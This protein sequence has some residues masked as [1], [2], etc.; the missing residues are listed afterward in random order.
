VP[1]E[2]IGANLA[3]V[4]RILY[5]VVPYLAFSMIAGFI[6]SKLH[7]ISINI[8]RNEESSLYGDGWYLPGGVVSFT[9]NAECPR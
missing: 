1:T 5:D 7:D 2:S 6:G 4:I 8:N 3:I 9:E